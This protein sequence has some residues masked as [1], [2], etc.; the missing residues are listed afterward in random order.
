MPA[1][2]GPGS[3]GD[4]VGDETPPSL[5][6]SV[7]L[8]TCDPE[9]TLLQAALE[10]LSRQSMPRATWELVLVDNGSRLPLTEDLFLGLNLP[11]ARLIREPCRGLARARRAGFVAA[12]GRVLVCVDDDNELAP[13]YL[14]QAW[15]IARANPGLGVWGGRSEPAFEVPPLTWTRP[16]LDHLAI[17]DYGRKVI[18]SRRQ[19]WGPWDPIGAG[20]VLRRAV[21]A[22]YVDFLANDHRGVSLGRTPELL[23]GGEDTLL[24]RLGNRLGFAC[25]YQPSLRLTHHIRA[26]RLG[27]RYL[28]RLLY[29]QGVTQARLALLLGTG[30]PPLQSDQ[31][32]GLLRQRWTQRRRELGRCGPIQWYWDLGFALE[33][34]R[35]LGEDIPPSDDPAGAGARHG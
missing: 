29:A 3:G 14:Q 17:R 2:P 5:D 35:L 12:R 26:H 24:N 15:R 34:R 28:R 13:D 9:A 25:S 18:T 16:L 1:S 32:R 22:A 30:L 11:G 27:P 23:L 33:T 31:C 19:E 20:M 4:R 7:V 10:S 21:A 6:L 8:C